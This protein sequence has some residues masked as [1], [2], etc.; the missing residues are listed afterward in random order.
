MS[1][2]SPTKATAPGDSRASAD[3]TPLVIGDLVVLSSDDLRG[4]VS[5]SAAALPRIVVA[6]APLSAEQREHLLQQQRLLQQRRRQRP[7]NDDD[8][9]D[10]PILPPSPVLD[11]DRLAGVFVVQ[12]P[13]KFAATKDYARR[14]S[15]DAQCTVEQRED[16]RERAVIESRNNIIEQRRLAGKPVTFGM[17]IQ[18]R[19]VLTGL[20]LQV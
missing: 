20:V 2:S 8:E 13:D 14:L 6:P 15:P 18:L 5:V 4:I 9:E 11:G 10:V 1:V 12:A 3:T 16:A 17:T 7:A 19:H